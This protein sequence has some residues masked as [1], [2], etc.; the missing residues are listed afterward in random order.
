MLYAGLDLS[1]RKVSVHVLDEAGA[2]VTATWVPATRDGLRLLLG[3]AGGD[4][5]RRRDSQPADT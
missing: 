5:D 2:T 4:G 1:R 3:T